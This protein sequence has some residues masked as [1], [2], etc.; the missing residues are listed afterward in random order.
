MT[1][2]YDPPRY[3]IRSR[4]YFRPTAERWRLLHVLSSMIRIRD[5]VNEGNG[6][7][8]SKS[9]MARLEPAMLSV[10]AVATPIQS[11]KFC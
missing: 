1:P 3:E 5:E 4:G 2:P 11:A 7:S 6:R 9:C 10:P 8:D